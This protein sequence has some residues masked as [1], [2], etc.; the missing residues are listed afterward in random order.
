MYL[1]CTSA[2]S[3]CFLAN[4]SIPPFD[5]SGYDTPISSI[6]FHS[7]WNS[8]LRPDFSY[9]C[10]RNFAVFYMFLFETSALTN[11]VLLLGLCILIFVPIKYVYPSRLDYLTKSYALKIVMHC[12]SI[13]YGISTALILLN[14]PNPAKIWVV[15]SA[16]YI[17]LYL[18]LSVFRTFVPLIKAKFNKQSQG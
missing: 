8:T 13:L 14:Y 6:G 1:Q 18:F 11:T 5:L 15:L 12:C 4:I 2:I 10:P 17:A 7:K 3:I 9:R 16:G